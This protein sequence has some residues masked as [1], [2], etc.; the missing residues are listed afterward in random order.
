MELIHDVLQRYRQLYGTDP[1]VIVRAPGR[2]NLI[3]EHTDYND[4]FVLP[5][6]IDK[7]VVVAA[8][9]R[10]DQLLHLHT[11]DFQKTVEV[12]LAE[13]AYDENVL[14]SN[15][16]IG[17]ASTLIAEGF[18]LCG[19]N[20]CFRGN[21]PIAAGLSSS[22]AIEVD[23]VL[24]FKH[25]NRLDLSVSEIIR[26]ARKAETGFVGV[27]CGIMDQFVS[28]HGRTGK[29]VFLDCKTLQYEYVQIPEGV[30]LIVFDTG[31]RRELVRS[32]YNRREAECEEALRQISKVFKPLTSLREISMIEFERIQPAL[33]QMTQKRARHVISENERVQKGVELLQRKDVHG[34]GKLMFESH[35]SLQND[36][37]VSCH[38]LDVF[39]DIARESQGVLGA[40]MN[41]A[42]FGGSAI[43]LVENDALDDFVKHVR[44][45]YPRRASH[46][47]TIYLP[48]IGD[49]AAIAT[50][51]TSWNPVLV[52]AS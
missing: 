32:A 21:V 17:V 30:A 10:K 9:K 34:F 28:M 44:V 19:A 51:E 18:N 1:E 20:F 23:C 41:G 43:A 3:G 22:A 25:L 27:Q 24:A 16:P 35:K 37:E 38:E 31:V 6:A 45:E 2:V 49:G 47:L 40:R 39:V 7:S 50:A 46:S 8:G 12:S 5:V 11:V 52:S 48:F 15:Y 4:G 29:A 36:Y 33:T 13:L 26:L 14:W 42:G